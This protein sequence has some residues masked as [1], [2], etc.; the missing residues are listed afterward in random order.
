M[1]GG[2]NNN[3]S[4]SLQRPSVRAVPAL[5]MKISCQRCLKFATPLGQESENFAGPARTLASIYSMRPQL[6]ATVVD[7]DHMGRA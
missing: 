6:K 7:A 2:K 3:L 4:T 5:C 1:H